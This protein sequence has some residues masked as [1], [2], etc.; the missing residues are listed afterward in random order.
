[1]TPHDIFFVLHIMY[2]SN[3]DIINDILDLI[4]NYIINDDQLQALVYIVNN[5][6]IRHDT[7]NNIII[8]MIDNYKILLIPNY[9]NCI[10]DVL[11][12]III[13]FNI[14]CNN[15][16]KIYTFLVNIILKNEDMHNKLS[17]INILLSVIQNMTI[18]PY[19]LPD[20]CTFA[21]NTFNNNNNNSIKL[22]AIKILTHVIDSTNDIKVEL[23]D[24]CAIAIKIINNCN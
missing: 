22:T 18:E 7:A 1:M 15:I 14:T 4:I 6:M 23:S 16:I 21:I 20:L 10:F 13:I 8:S 9:L 17:A 3:D 12:V 5:K 11:S 24:L 19:I 2:F